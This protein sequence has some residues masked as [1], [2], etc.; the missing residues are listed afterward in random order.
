[1]TFEE[2]DVLNRKKYS[3]F[4]TEIISNYK[5]YKRVNDSKSFTLAIDSSWGTGKTT[6]I[7]KWLNEL[8]CKKDQKNEAKYHIIKYNAWENDFFDDCL[9]SLLYNILIDES[10]YFKDD[11]EKSEEILKI[12]ASSIKNISKIALKGF[13]T[14]KIGVENSENIMEIINGLIN[15][16]KGMKSEYKKESSF[17]NLFQEFN[18]YRITLNE[19]KKILGEVAAEK[20]FIIIIDEL[21]R[22]KPTFAIQLLEIV[23]HI[24][25]VPN[26]SFVFSLDISQLSHSIKLVYGNNMDGNGYLIRFFDYI[27]KMPSFDTEQ[28]IEYIVE[29]SKLYNSDLLENIDNGINGIL[30]IDFK[31]IFKIFAKVFNLSLRDINTIYSNF[32]L[33]EEFELKNYKNIRAYELYL[34]LLIM[35]Y[36]DNEC[37]DMIFRDNIN[38]ILVETTFINKMGKLSNKIFRAIKFTD[39][40]ND[41]TLK[42]IDFYLELYNS[43]NISIGKIKKVDLVNKRIIYIGNKNFNNGISYDESVNISNILFFDDIENWENIKDMTFR[44]FLN[45]KLEFFNFLNDINEEKEGDI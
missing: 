42:E 19:F 30:K 34:L 22:C 44:E 7:N 40:I 15:T 28:Y 43:D 17:D 41:K 12:G 2:D 32:K 23:K 9:Q 26:V 27:S 33:F 14:Q 8:N 16:F 5:K 20:P 18:A 39:F 3:E 25:D 6:F 35:K 11:I 24:F 10:F 29:N 21:D 37:F 36:K 13:I 31:Y 38:K 45:K 1:M 4:L